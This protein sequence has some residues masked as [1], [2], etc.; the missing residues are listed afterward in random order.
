MYTYYVKW[1]QFCKGLLKK[2]HIIKKIIEK[3]VNDNNILATLK[4][5]SY[6]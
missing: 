4:K 5:H 2:T 6:I 1:S 3:N